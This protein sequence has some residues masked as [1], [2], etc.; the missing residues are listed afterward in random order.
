MR[1]SSRWFVGVALLLLG[2]YF[3]GVNFGL[4]PNGFGRWVGS[5]WDLIWRFWPLLLIYLGW[6]MVASK[7]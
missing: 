7:R 5:L 6:Q 4:W 3:L 2:V 1:K